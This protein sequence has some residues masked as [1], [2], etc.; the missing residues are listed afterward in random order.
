MNVEQ[1]N[2][3]IYALLLLADFSSLIGCAVVLLGFWKLK[4]LRNHITKII[5]CFCATS[6]LKD[7]IATSLTLEGTAFKTKKWACYLYAASINFGSFSCW[8]WT[9]CLALSI[10]LLISRVQINQRKFEI[11]Y[12]VV[13]WGL[14]AI[15]TIIMLSTNIVSNVGSWCW[16]GTKFVY[17]RFGLFYI[18]FFVI[19]GAAAI[20]VGLTS[21]YTYVVM[22][23]SKFVRNENH[24]AVYQFK[25][26]NYIIVFLICWVFAVVNRILNAVNLNIYATNVLHTYLS[27]SHGFYASLVFIYNNPIMW[28]FFCSKVL[29]VCVFFGFGHKLYDH[30]RKNID[31]NNDTSNGSKTGQG[32]K[33]TLANRREKKKSSSSSSSSDGSGSPPL[34]SQS[35]QSDI[36]CVTN[37]LSS[38]CDGESHSLEMSGIHLNDQSSTDNQNNNNLNNLS[39]SDISTQD[40]QTI[41]STSV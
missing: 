29:A 30:Y 27:V 38:A 25:L 18:P 8:M 26:V 32:R 40:E 19:F 17:F 5:S 39:T 9:L 14:P 1:Q 37:T 24:H 33:I 28:R 35:P 31:H 15:S 20:L 22:H 34:D 16:I 2:R 4:L 7:I 12:M 21:H 11:I 36:T 23:N 10:Y 41:P 6:F 13:S 3:L